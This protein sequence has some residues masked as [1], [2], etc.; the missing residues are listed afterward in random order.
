MLEHEDRI[1]L[2]VLTLAGAIVI[3]LPLIAA[4]FH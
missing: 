3:S 1:V 4:A 2:T